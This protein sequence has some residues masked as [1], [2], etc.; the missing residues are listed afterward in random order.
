MFGVSDT[1][2]CPPQQ[3]FDER[4]IFGALLGDGGKV[5]FDGQPL[6][7]F[8]DMALEWYEDIDQM[9]RLVVADGPEDWPRIEQLSDRPDVEL[10]VPEDAVSDIVVEDDIGL[11]KTEIPEAAIGPA[12]TEL[13]SPKIRLTSKLPEARVV[14]SSKAWPNPPPTTSRV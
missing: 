2:G 8:H 13:V 6:P 10:G 11:G 12:G 5:G 4:S 9:H 3:I 14:V 1:L 7:G